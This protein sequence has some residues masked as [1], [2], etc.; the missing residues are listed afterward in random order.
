M[1]QHEHSAKCILGHG[2]P[3]KVFQVSYPPKSSPVVKI[4]AV[5][6]AE[7]NEFSPNGV[8]WD[9]DFF[10]EIPLRCCGARLNP[11]RSR[12]VRLG[13]LATKVATRQ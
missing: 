1:E 8:S 12:D 3:L 2:T 7:N 13:A 5:S 9:L 11:G 6:K 4:G 10:V